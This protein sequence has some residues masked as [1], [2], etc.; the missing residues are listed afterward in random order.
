MPEKTNRIRYYIFL[1]IIIIGS[2]YLFFN[3]Y[4]IFSYIKL[5]SEV[6]SLK[7][8]VEKLEDEKALLKAEIDSLKKRIPEKIERVAR[9]KY[10]MLRP[11]E[12][13]IEVIEKDE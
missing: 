6:D 8:E 1:I 5:E 7:A 13:K 9:E 2:A 10:D 12:T 11:G 3:K 4:G